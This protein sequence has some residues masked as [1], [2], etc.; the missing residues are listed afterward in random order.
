MEE[1]LSPGFCR[2]DLSTEWGLFPLEHLI[3]F[4][5]QWSAVRTLQ[6]VSGTWPVFLEPPNC[7]KRNPSSYRVWHKRPTAVPKIGT[8][9]STGEH[10]VL[11]VMLCIARC[12]LYLSLVLNASHA[13]QLL[14]Q[15]PK[16]F[17]CPYT[18]SGV[19]EVGNDI[20]ST[21]E[22]PAPEL[23]SQLSQILSLS[24]SRMSHVNLGL[25]PTFSVSPSTK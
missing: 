17:P 16:P 22:A 6:G 11:H 12:L 25:S 5:M 20:I 2:T 4:A 21:S 19:L 18:V 13:A 10:I 1:W 23:S 14:G 15:S 8:S 9:R 3:L 7:G 24:E